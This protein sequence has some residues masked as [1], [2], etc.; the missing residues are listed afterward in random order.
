M[1][2]YP[3]LHPHIAHAAIDVMDPAARVQTGPPFVVDVTR[4][5]VLIV[6]PFWWHHVETMEDSI[7]INAWSDAPGTTSRNSL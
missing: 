1:A 4:G 3:C 2:I 6:P 5:D 7:S